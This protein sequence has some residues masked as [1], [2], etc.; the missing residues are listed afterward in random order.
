MPKQSRG[1]GRPLETTVTVSQKR[2]L[3]AYQDYSAANGRAPTYRELA[4][5]LDQPVSAV[6]KSIGRLERNG[7][8]VRTAGKQRSIEIIKSVDDINPSLSDVPLVG[9]EPQSRADE[10]EGLPVPSV[11]SPLRTASPERP[12]PPQSPLRY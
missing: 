11:R 6:Y 4:D 7:Y 10:V 8:L 9:V 12:R 2:V 1:R 3:D 5:I